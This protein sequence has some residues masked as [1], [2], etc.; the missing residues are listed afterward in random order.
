MQILLAS[1][2]IM[3]A[4]TSVDIPMKSKPNHHEKNGTV[5]IYGIKN[6]FLTNCGF[7]I[8]LLQIIPPWRNE[9][10]CRKTNRGG[11]NMNVLLINGSPHKSAPA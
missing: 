5:R 10:L 9:Y 6:S 4:A 11:K 8:I 2:K 3:N 7:L 1:A